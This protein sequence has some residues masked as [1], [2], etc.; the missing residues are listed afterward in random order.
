MTD[1]KEEIAKQCSMDFQSDWRA[2]LSQKL[3]DLGYPNTGLD[4]EWTLFNKIANIERR[5]VAAKP[6]TLFV[7]KELACPVDLQSGLEELKRKVQAGE[8]LRPH[9]STGILRIE[10]ED[11]LLNDWG[12]HHFHLGTGPHR[13]LPDFN[14][15]TGPVLFARV[16]QDAFYMINVLGH[17]SWTDTDLIEILHRNW[18]ASIIK[19]KANGVVGVAWPNNQKP[20]AQ[21]RQ[22]MRKAGINV[23]IELADGTVYNPLALGL[24][25]A[26]TNV[27]VTMQFNAYRRAMKE[28][29][30]Q[31]LDKM[32]DVLKHAKE[33][34]LPMKPPYLLRFQGFHDRG[35]IIYDEANDVQF[36]IDVLSEKTREHT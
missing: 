14:E 16:T 19:F 2:R 5:N 27:A 10:E 13:S 9:L 34:G 7:S 23:F 24:T 36:V 20:T 12:I 31:V 26:G 3:A 21:E 32:P 11:L 8:D 6:R 29:S 33:I 15:R 4:D 30:K 17:G 22:R 1:P 18:P 25:S 35:P 28:L